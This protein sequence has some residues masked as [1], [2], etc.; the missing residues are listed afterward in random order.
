MLKILSNNVKHTHTKTPQIS[1]AQVGGRSQVPDLQVQIQGHILYIEKT[2]QLER[3][4]MC[5]SLSLWGIFTVNHWKG[6]LPVF[7]SSGHITPKQFLSV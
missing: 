7:L 1:V 6:G 3:C 5:L 2:E 4:T